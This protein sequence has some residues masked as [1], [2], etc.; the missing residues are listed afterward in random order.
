MM[1]TV[2]TPHK[3][4]AAIGLAVFILG[5]SLAWAG[6]TAFT[7]WSLN[8]LNVIEIDIEAGKVS[9]E[10]PDGDTAILMVGDMVGQEGATITEIRKL[11]VIL[12]V[13]P[14]NSG[15][16]SKKYIPVVRFEFSAPLKTQ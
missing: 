7:D 2:K 4:L 8:K 5:S 10:S 9:L 1:T 16:T 13:P 11:T 6:N 14:D 3:F 12:E 15:K